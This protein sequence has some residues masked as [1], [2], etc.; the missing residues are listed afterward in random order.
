MF[1]NEYEVSVT[2]EELF[3]Y[4]QEVAK[5]IYGTYIWQGVE[6]VI[7]KTLNDNLYIEPGDDTNE[8]I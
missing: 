8:K 2:P 3:K 1:N 5:M 4:Q 7:R 6:N